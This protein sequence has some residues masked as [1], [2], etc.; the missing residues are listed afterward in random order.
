MPVFRVTSPDGKTYEV[1]A[2]EGATEQE[3]ISY[4]MTQHAPTEAKPNVAERQNATGLADQFARQF[5]PG[6]EY[7]GAAARYGA[8][9]LFGQ[10]DYTYDQALKD[11]R[12]DMEAYS[13]KNPISS[14]IAQTAGAIT[15]PL[16]N[17]LAAKIGSA[18][19]GAG[20]LAKYTRF[21]G[22]GGAIGATA[23][24]LDARDNQ[25]G[26]PSG[27][28]LLEGGSKGATI[29]TLTGVA[30][31]AIGSAVVGG[32]KMLGNAVGNVAAK[33]STP[34]N[35]GARRLEKALARDNLTVPQAQQRLS[36]LG[37]DATIADLGGNVRG[38]AESAAT[39]PGATLKAAEALG[40]RQYGQSERIRAA[41]LK[42]TGAAHI[43]ELI[44]KRSVEASPLY[45]AAFAPQVGPVT[46][47]SQQITSPTIERMLERPIIQ[48]GIQKGVANILDEAAATGRQ[49]PLSDF[50]LRRNPE[51][52]QFE[53]IGTPTLRLLDAAKRGLDQFMDTDA[54]RNPLTGKLTE[55]GRVVET[56]RK[57]LVNQL[58]DLAPKN[59]KGQSLYKL[60]RDKWAEYSKPIEALATIDKVLN[61]ARDASDVT[62]RLFGS[63]DARAKLNGL[64]PTD[65]ISEFAK[66][67]E[68]E[69]T[70][71]QTNRQLSGNSRTAY[72]QAAQADAENGGG[73]DAAVAFA[74]NPTPTNALF[75]LA[76]GI[77]S[78]VTGPSSEVADALA[79]IVSMNPHE[80][81]AFLRAVENR[82]NGRGL[83]A[84]TAPKI[85]SYFNLLGGNDS[86]GRVARG[87]NP[88]SLLG[89]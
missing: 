36:E 2:P 69:K 33:F 29:G 82:I 30:L 11:E 72:R 3:A 48:E 80:R 16:Y 12:G 47:K 79:P 9:K 1:T 67:L 40:D 66:V 20:T 25:G 41:A 70:F 86:L 24:L 46:V 54:A 28:D 52:G 81:D 56:M 13:N 83:L 58:D 77:K 75:Q 35:Q 43:D 59:E 10:G 64:G 85:Q 87:D 17:A 88:W 57:T 27:G 62:G 14:G 32:A 19:P 74:S 51:T 15:N 45:E 34:E 53:R 63:P 6:Y 31:P 71:A 61:N 38:L 55:R 50:A 8:K 21:G 60:A 4:A 7:A 39:Q 78:A 76:R 65:K 68:T 18:I 84:R 5:V 44:A 26:L 22:Q 49:I 42:A 23:G 89:P 73:V 37:P